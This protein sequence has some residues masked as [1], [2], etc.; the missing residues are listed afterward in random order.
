MDVGCLHV[1]DFVSNAAVNIGTII[2][3]QVLLLFPLDKYSVVELP[4]PRNHRVV[5][6]LFEG[7]PYCFP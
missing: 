4:N 3:F 2:S 5:F 7:R 1:L 6:R